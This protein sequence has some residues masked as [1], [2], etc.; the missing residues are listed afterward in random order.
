[1]TIKVS[2]EMFPLNQLRD[3]YRPRI[4]STAFFNR[5]PFP[6]ISFKLFTHLVPKLPQTISTEYSKVKEKALQRLSFYTTGGR[7]MLRDID[8]TFIDQ[9]NRL[10][11]VLQSGEDYIM[12][13]PPIDVTQTEILNISPLKLIVST[14]EIKKYFNENIGKY[15]FLKEFANLCDKT[16]PKRAIFSKKTEEAV[17]YIVNLS[18]IRENIGSC[19]KELDDILNNAS[20]ILCKEQQK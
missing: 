17:S 9:E 5:K 1:M 16:I 13:T 10:V 15:P 7:F 12:L 3:E 2:S 20:F 4:G 18:W 6:F 19:I 11:A 8:Y 14:Y